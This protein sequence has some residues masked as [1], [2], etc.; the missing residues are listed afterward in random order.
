MLLVLTTLSNDYLDSHR[1]CRSET[2][3]VGLAAE[4]VVVGSLL[5][6]NALRSFQCSFSL[7]ISEVAVLPDVP[8][9]LEAIGSTKSSL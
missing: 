5:E 2:K 1:Y 7:L 8:I 3:V 9:L 4:A 6:M